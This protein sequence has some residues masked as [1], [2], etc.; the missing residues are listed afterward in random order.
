ME[1]QIVRLDLPPA[2]PL[3]RKVVKADDQPCL[4]GVLDQLDFRRQGLLI[5]G[6]EV[7]EEGRPGADHIAVPGGQ[8][9][10]Q[11][12]IAVGTADTVQTLQACQNGLHIAS[13]QNR[14]VYPIPFHDGNT[15]A[16]PLP[17]DDGDACLA[18]RLHIPID[19]TAGDFKAL[20]QLRGSD[21]VPLEQ[22]G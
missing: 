1:H 6:G 3:G 16:C 20:R 13:A 7:D 14:P 21:T 15:A 11:L 18:E 12:G 8:L 9:L 22:Y 10:H 5:P 2:L 4:N 17:G 19:G